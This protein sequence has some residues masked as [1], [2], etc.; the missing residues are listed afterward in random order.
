MWQFN[1]QI[2]EQQLMMLMWAAFNLSEMAKNFLFQF[3]QLI[4]ASHYYKPEQLLPQLR[5]KLV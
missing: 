3:L 1:T 4:S 2:K 5:L